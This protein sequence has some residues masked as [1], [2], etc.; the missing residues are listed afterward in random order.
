[1]TDDYRRELQEHVR[2]SMDPHRLRVADRMAEINGRYIGLTRDGH[3]AA[4]L[5]GLVASMSTPDP[6]EQD[7]RRIVALVGESDAGKTTALKRHTADISALQPFVS[8]ATTFK[9]FLKML[10][11]SPSSLDL[12]GAEMMRGVGYPVR[13]DAKLKGAWQQACDMLPRHRVGCI[14]IDE[15]QDAVET[16]SI[17]EAK[18]I[19]NAF[20]NLVQMP[21]WPVRLILS[22]V[23]PLKTFLERPQL[24]SRVTIVPFDQIDPVLNG[25]TIDTAMEMIIEDHAGLSRSRELTKGAKTYDDF[26]LRLAHGCDKEFGSVV[27]TIR[28][29][30]ELA[31]LERTDLVTRDHFV[32]AYD[33]H[34]GKPPHENVF[35]APN[36]AELVVRQ[37]DVEGSVPTWARVGAKK[38]RR[39]YG[40]RP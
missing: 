15:A 40:E 7:K 27:K 8:G 1:M 9:P 30:V 31:L 26:R 34:A 23:Q 38:T 39:K 19:G 20:K 12:V 11:P 21:D 17:P 28:G 18:V 5:E 3:L 24:K 22:G 37:A 32:R 14:W 29:V 36:W 6:D 10:A 33:M 4:A 2:A 13:R 25:D 35:T 16:A